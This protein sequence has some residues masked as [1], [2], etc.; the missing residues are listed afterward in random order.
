VGQVIFDC[1]ARAQLERL[2]DAGQPELLE[3]GIRSSVV[4]MDHL[5]PVDELVDRAGEAPAPR[6][7]DCKVT[8]A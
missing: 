8:A 3:E 6:S 4:L 7:T 2:Q 1:L 5:C